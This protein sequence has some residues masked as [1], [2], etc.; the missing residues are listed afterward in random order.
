MS[1][2]DRDRGSRHRGG[3]DAAP[4][5]GARAL[6]LRHLA[7]GPPPTAPLQPLADAALSDRQRVAVLLQAAGLVAHLD[8]A[9]CHL[10]GGWASARLTADGLLR[11]ARVR[12]GRSRALPQELLT[13]LTGRLFG[14]AAEVAGRG[15]A[16]R[17]ARELLAGWAQTLAPVPSD[18]LVEQILS[19]APFLWEEAFGAAHNAL[20]S[21]HLQGGAHHL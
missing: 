13:D 3:A 12:S 15:E 20:A 19:A 17:S 8:H 2:H 7:L 4:A 16:R 11:V 14:S 1:T 18:E 21:E 10:D 6:R 5:A 9:G